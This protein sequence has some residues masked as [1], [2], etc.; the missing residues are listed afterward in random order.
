MRQ[1]GE[2]KSGYPC[3]PDAAASQARQASHDP[4]YFGPKPEATVSAKRW[5]SCGELSEWPRRVEY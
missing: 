4:S 3:S 5:R 2:G 1:L